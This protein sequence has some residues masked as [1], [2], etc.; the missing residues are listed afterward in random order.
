MANTYK[1]MIMGKEYVLT[2][3]DNKEY[4]EKLA[5][6]LDKRIRDMRTKFTS[7]SITDCA[8]LIALDCMDELGQSNRNID[9][10]RTQIKDYVDDAGRARTQANSVQRENKMLRERVEQLEREL[11]ERTNFS[12]TDNVGESISAE[13]MPSRDIKEALGDTEDETSA[14]VSESPEEAAEAVKNAMQ[15]DNRPVDGVVGSVWYG[16]KGGNR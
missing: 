12:S 7:L 3:E 5:A 15:Q 9:N 13:A 6:N 11:R 2:S 8:V 4:T 16:N 14:A 1:V 10:I